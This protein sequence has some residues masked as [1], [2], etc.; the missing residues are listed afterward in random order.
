MKANCQLEVIVGR[1]ILPE[2]TY[3]RGALVWTTENNA[4]H[5]IEQKICRFQARMLGPD[6]ARQAGPSEIKK[7]LP[8]EPDTLSIGS[9]KSGG[10]SQEAPLSA[11]QEDQ[12]SQKSKPGLLQR[13]KAVLTRPHRVG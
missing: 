12:V 5:Y 3:E 7:S 6:E 4:K 11:S 9:A 8:A 2:G 1:A 13:G 10:H